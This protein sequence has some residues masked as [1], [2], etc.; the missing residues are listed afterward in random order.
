M[1]TPI[2]MMDKGFSGLWGALV[3]RSVQCIE[4]EV[5]AHRF[6]PSPTHDTARVHVD[7][8]RRINEARSGRYI[9]EIGHPQS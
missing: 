7:N 2:G 5:G 4:S 9:R 6:R 1:P 3:K 8:K